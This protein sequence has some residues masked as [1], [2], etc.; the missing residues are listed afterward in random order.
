M[1]LIPSFET[2]VELSGSARVVPVRAEFIRRHEAVAVAV[3]ISE[4]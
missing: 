3:G 1:N 4:L 2:F